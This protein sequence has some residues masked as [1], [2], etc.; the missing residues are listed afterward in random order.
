NRDVLKVPEVGEVVLPVDFSETEEAMRTNLATRAMARRLLKDG[1][2]LVIFPAGG[3][4][5]SLRPFG[6]AEE[7]PWKLFTARLVQQAEAS[8]L[9]V[10]FEG[11]NSR[12]FQLA[13]RVSLPLRLS[14]LVSEFRRFAGARVR[15]H[16]GAVVPFEALEHRGDRRRLT[17]ELYARVHKLAPGNRSKELAELRP[18]PIVDRP[19]FPW[20]PRASQ[21]VIEVQTR[22]L[23]GATAPTKGRQ[24]LL[25]A[26][27]RQK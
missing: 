25:A 2:T 5:T 13:S 15:V 8:V 20:E 17:D 10:F 1:V 11:Q 3:V 6:P 12:L 4:A 26:S 23:S 21:P 16:V 27:L 7:L 24:A 19:R 9:P 14:L 18:S 22:G